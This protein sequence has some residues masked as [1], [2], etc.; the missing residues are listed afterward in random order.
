MSASLRSAH[1]ASSMIM[2]GILPQNSHTHA[3]NL[4]LGLRSVSPVKRKLSPR[5]A[6][7]ASKPGQSTRCHV[8]W[9]MPAERV[10]RASAVRQPLASNPRWKLR[11]SEAN[12]ILQIEY[13][14][15]PPRRLSYL[16]GSLSASSGLGFCFLRRPHEL[17]TR[18]ALRV[19]ANL[20]RELIIGN[21]QSRCCESSIHTHV[22]QV[23]RLLST[24]CRSTDRPSLSV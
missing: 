16:L 14:Q 6:F 5:Q 9:C 19:G 17:R 1:P 10:H 18:H 24:P 8:A 15:T 2:T 7:R 4:S 12:S 22:R 13:Q 20:Y 21:T 11:H 23:R 3:V